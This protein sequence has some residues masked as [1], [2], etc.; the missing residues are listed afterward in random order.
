MTKVALE[1]VAAVAANG[2]IGRGGQLP[3][4]LPDDLRHFKA[5]TMG[6]AV[7][8]GRKTYESVGR[9]LPGRTT[10]VVSRSLLEPPHEHVRLVNS[11]EAAIESAA[12]TPPPAYV[13]GG[14]AIY[15][16]AIPYA[17]AIHLTELDEP[18]EGDTYFPSFDRSA[19]RIAT[20]SVH[21]RDASHNIGFRIRKYVRG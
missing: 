21:S 3:W 11:L 10:I 20:E 9:P 2:V 8:M 4:H 14:A 16:T 5:L 15:E 19:W 12:S 13:V 18:V 6:H 1:L 7:I 17:M